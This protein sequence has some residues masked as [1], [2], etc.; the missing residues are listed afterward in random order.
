MLIDLERGGG[1]E[2]G[3]QKHGCERET[4]ISCL[5]YVP[6]PGTKPMP[7]PLG[8]CP[9]L[10]DWKSNLLLGSWAD[11]PSNSATP[12]RARPLTS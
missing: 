8:V 3:E 12:A 2:R 5:L 10:H 11:A 6:Q 1:K 9:D 4:L 7:N